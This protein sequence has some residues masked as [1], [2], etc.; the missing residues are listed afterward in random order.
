MAGG[1]C[2]YLRGA[3][4]P[5]EE[6]VLAGVCPAKGAACDSLKDP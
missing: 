1:L 3:G 6:P 5:M 4:G 2:S